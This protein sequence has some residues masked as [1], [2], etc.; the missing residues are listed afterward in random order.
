MNQN[1]N[2]EDNNTVEIINLPVDS[3][4]LSPRA[5]N[6]IKRNR[7]F[8][9]QELIECTPSDIRKIKNIGN[10]TFDNIVAALKCVGMTLKNEINIKDKNILKKE[11]SPETTITKQYKGV[12]TD[13]EPASVK[14]TLTPNEIKISFE[15][16]DTAEPH[17]SKS[18]TINN[19]NF[20]NE[21]QT[22]IDNTNTDDIVLIFTENSEL[23][24]NDKVLYIVKGDKKTIKHRLINAINASICMCY[25]Q[26]YFVSNPC[27][28]R[29]DLSQNKSILTI[30]SNGFIEKCYQQMEET[31]P[32]KQNCI[33]IPQSVCQSVLPEI[34]DAYKNLL[35]PYLK[36]K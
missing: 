13:I 33:F 35:K 23:N 12:I 2:N 22:Q 31:E 11:L 20:I 1:K 18:I 10:S 19:N 27:R 3:L 15:I 26:N 29:Y 36:T 4:K 8:T 32:T 7:I 14:D 25:L 9:V 28:Y 17:Q 30:I 16:K 34:L 5:L 6:A 24:K 21:V